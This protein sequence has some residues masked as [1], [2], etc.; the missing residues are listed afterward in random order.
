EVG[1]G[2]IAD[3][4]RKFNEQ[5][6]AG[7][8]GA[9]AD[10]AAAD[11]EEAM[12]QF[13]T[14]QGYRMGRFW[15]FTVE[16]G[17]QYRYR[18]T[19]VLRNPNRGYTKQ[20][21][22]DEALAQ[23][24]FRPNSPLDPADTNRPVSEA[25]YVV[26]IPGRSEIAVGGVV[27]DGENGNRSGEDAATVVFTVWENT[28]GAIADYEQEVA[29]IRIPLKR[30]PAQAILDTLKQVW[31]NVDFVEAS[32]ESRVF[33][34]QFL[35]RNMPT[36]V[37]HPLYNKIETLRNVRFDTS[38]TLVD[39]VGGQPPAN[40]TGAAAPAATTMVPPAEYL[41]IDPNGNLVIRSE[42]GDRAAYRRKLA[43]VSQAAAEDAAGGTN[44]IDQLNN[45]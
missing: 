11:P 23:G 28:A 31:A 34:G 15:D 10:T 40:A 27:P 35:S 18:V 19:L 25:S 17:A 30:A 37:N 6:A 16:P 1:H 7:A 8:T 13:A 22:K 42:I 38:F 20:Y 26:A 24:A 44:T 14:K 3:M 33:R 32:S 12:R 43:A 29:A 41:L 36:A 39:I 5:T 9:A 21:L 2:L 4:V 45:R